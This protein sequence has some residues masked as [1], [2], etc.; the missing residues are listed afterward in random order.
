MARPQRK[1]IVSCAVTGAIHVPSLTPHLPITPAEIAAQ[2]IGAARAG[3][4]ILHLH[5]RDPAD[6]RPTPD[7]EVYARFLGEIHESCDA[8]VNITTGGGLGMSL[9]ERLAAVRRF[10]PELCSLNMGSFNFGIFPMAAGISEFKHDWEKPYLDGTTDFIF[11]NTFADIETIVTEIGA[12]GTRFEFECYDVGHLYNL[13]HFLD[14]GVLKPPLFVQCILGILGGVGPD[15]ENL[16][17]MKTT[18]D[19]LFGDE[20]LFS[21]LGAGRHQTRLVTV[22]AIM[23]GN[24]RVGLEDSVY[25][26]RGR[27]AESNAQQVEKIVRIL[28]E[29]SLDVATPDEARE[30]LGL[31]G[32]DNT[33]LAG[34]VAGRGRSG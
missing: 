28:R 7:P 1:A 19:R 4:A 26:E 15:V 5:A 3:A 27:L 13:A 21:V 17:H 23:G 9:D 14:R 24:V 16:V 6:G 10:D 33:A 30:M 11:K 31:K 12:R 32:R 34:A 22:G 2:A 25:L 8:V 20:Y 18:A 29:L